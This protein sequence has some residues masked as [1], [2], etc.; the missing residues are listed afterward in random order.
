MQ[1]KPIIAASAISMALEGVLL[2]F[3]PE[4]L[5][6]ALNADVSPISLLLGQVLGALYLGFAM[7][8]WM[9]R[10]SP[11][12]GIY[13]RPL[14]VANLLHFLVAG[15]ALIKY[16]LAAPSQPLILWIAAGLYALFAVLFGRMMFT[17]PKAG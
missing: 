12:G 4:L 16:V 13:N 14:V 1:T 11:T 2:T 10:G 9:G 17:S 3:A 7:L 8:N 5:L 15:L 6:A